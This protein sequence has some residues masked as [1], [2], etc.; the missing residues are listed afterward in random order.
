[1]EQVY[2]LYDTKPPRLVSPKSK[3]GVMTKSLEQIQEEQTEETQRGV[4][5]LL[6]N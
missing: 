5:E 4:N 6:N 2:Y 3:R 1:M